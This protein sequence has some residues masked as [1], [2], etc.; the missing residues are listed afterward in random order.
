MSQLG[1]SALIGTYGY[2]LKANLF[3]LG[4]LLLILVKVFFPSFIYLLIA[5]YGLVILLNQYKIVLRDFRG[6]LFG[7]LSAFIVGIA[8]AAFRDGS[9]LIPFYLFGHLGFCVLLFR[10]RIN[11]F[12]VKV[13]L[14]LFTLYVSFHALVLGTD[15]NY[16]V[17][18]SRNLVG[19]VGLAL[20]IL[21][22]GIKYHNKQELDVHTA[23]IVLF[24]ALVA[25]GR[26]TIIAAVVML[27]GVLVHKF[28]YYSI[29]KKLLFIGGI[30][31][32]SIVTYIYLSSFIEEKLYRFGDRGFDSSERDIM[33]KA[34]LNKIDGSTL[35]SGV[36]AE[37]YPF[38][39]L[40]GNFHNSFLLAHSTFGF[41]FFVIISVL[42]ISFF[43]RGAK[44]IF[45]KFLLLSYCLRISTDT[46]AFVGFFDFL[47]L[48]L[49]CLIFR[50]KTHES[51]GGLAY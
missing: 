13:I 31:L 18:G 21:Y 23:I 29:L 6:L 19:W 33:L 8:I 35:I 24:L 45:P 36:S 42:L 39:L 7:V 46:I 17:G 51:K 22:Y 43:Y 34:Y 12:M 44:T 26:S 15:L 20:G 5:L 4:Y 14:C 37:Q 41:I 2:D 3:L 38:S 10:Y 9:F 11:A 49:L 25:V 32:S 16:L 47:M 40:E 48:F 50:P 27:I 30:I 28:D 1:K